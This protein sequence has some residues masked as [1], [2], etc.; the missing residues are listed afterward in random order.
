M[1]M[2]LTNLGQ[3]LAF[4]YNQGI[5]ATSDSHNVPNSIVTGKHKKIFSELGNR[6]VGTFRE[7]FGDTCHGRPGIGGR[8]I[9]FET[10]TGTQN[11]SF[12]NLSGAANLVGRRVPVTLCN[13][14]LFTDLNVGVVNGKTNAVD[15]Q[16]L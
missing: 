8:V 13:S 7:E 2:A 1:K 10:I 12:G 14:E 5:Q 11:S 4:S 3:N 15:L 6:K 16:S 9:N